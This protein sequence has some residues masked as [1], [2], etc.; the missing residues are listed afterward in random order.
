MTMLD[1]PSVPIP[2]ATRPTMKASAFN[3]SG[4]IIRRWSMTAIASIKPASTAPPAPLHPGAAMTLVKT[5][6]PP[7]APTR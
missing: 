5:A 3:S 6:P 1:V 2:A 7:A 4:M